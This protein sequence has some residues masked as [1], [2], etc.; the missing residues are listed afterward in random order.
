MSEQQ[1]P[2]S[3]EPA[4]ILRPLR[5]VRQIR[6]FSDEPVRGAEVDAIVDVG[7]W[8]GSSRNAQPWRFVVIRDPAML[9]RIGELGAPSTRALTTANAAIVVVMPSETVDSASSGFDDG[10]ATE[11]MLVAA[12]LLGLGASL[13]WVPPR[14]RSEV[15]SLLGVPDDRVVRT[16]LAVGHPAA[17]AAAPRTPGV[18]ARLPRSETVFA[19]R[20]GDVAG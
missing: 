2:T 17:E 10:R 5:R 1:Q 6:Q 13:C 14:A 4:D 11:R 20:W 16:M 12:H 19:E 8:S 15:A 18:P 3:P 9:V 7:R